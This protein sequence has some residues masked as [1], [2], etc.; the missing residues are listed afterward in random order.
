ML[1]SF[2]KVMN[3]GTRP[4]WNLNDLSDF[5]AQAEYFSTLRGKRGFKITTDKSLNFPHNVS[6]F[7]G[8]KLVERCI[9]FMA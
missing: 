4:V 5:E 1:I 3:F 9:M 8:L 6:Y 7:V 2:I